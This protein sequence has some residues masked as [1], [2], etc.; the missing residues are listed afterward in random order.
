[1]VARRWRK[2]EEAREEK[3]SIQTRKKTPV[4][5]ARGNQGWETAGRLERVP[6]EAVSVPDP[7]P[8]QELHPCNRRVSAIT[9]KAST[10]SPSPRVPFLLPLRVRFPLFSLVLAGF[11]PRRGDPKKIRS[12]L[13]VCVLSG[14]PLLWCSEFLSSL[15]EKTYSL[16][17]FA[18]PCVLLCDWCALLSLLCISSSVK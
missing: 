8:P 9:Q 13:H 16:I 5:D 10:P 6:P 11:H 15:C 4:N 18:L 3:R 7:R 12:L 2:K 14:T 17:C 1:M